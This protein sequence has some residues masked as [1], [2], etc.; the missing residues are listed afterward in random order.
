M[1]NSRSWHLAIWFWPVDA[2]RTLI[3]AERLFYEAKT[4]GE[5]LGQAFSKVRAREVLREDLNTLEA[6]QDA[7]MSGAMRY[8]LLSQQELPIQHHFKVAEDMIAQP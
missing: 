4:A 6:T 1:L 7:L 8:I 3:R 2:G 5:R